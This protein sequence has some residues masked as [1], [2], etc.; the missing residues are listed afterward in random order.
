VREL[1]S[2]DALAVYEGALRE[3]PEGAGG[4]HAVGEDGS[5]RRLPIGR[6]L[7]TP[8]AVEQE[9]LGRA[10][11]PVLDI[12]CGV[13]RHVVAL[14]RRG[15]RAVGIEISTVAAAIARERGAEV[16]QGSIFDQSLAPVWA[17]ILLLDGNIG[18]GGDACRLLAH[19]AA[20]SKP[21][22]RI[23]VELEPPASASP[24]RRVRLEDARLVSHWMP[25]HFVAVEEID[26]LAVAA[27]LR[28]EDRWRAGERWF[29]ELVP[30]AEGAPCRASA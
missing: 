21:G 17:T 5:R 29:A 28:V 4:L 27:G 1:S 30:A 9:V 10:I 26:E 11:G 23:L 25:W 6:W 24:A 2:V 19:A 7:G 13:G 20:L 16:I 22:G 12:G 8:D 3:T 15:V 18:I 14:G